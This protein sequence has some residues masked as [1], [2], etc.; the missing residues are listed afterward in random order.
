MPHSTQS[1]SS[2]NTAVHAVVLVLGLVVPLAIGWE[3][4][5]P[6]VERAFWLVMSYFVELTIWIAFDVVR[7]IIREPGREE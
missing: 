2:R 6:P 5:G 3:R 7:G 4:N 1:E